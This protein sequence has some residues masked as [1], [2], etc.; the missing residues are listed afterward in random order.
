MA[1]AGDPPVPA[2]SPDGC[3]QDRFAAAA[4]WRDLLGHARPH[5]TASDSQETAPS[6]PASAL[7]L[8]PES[9]ANRA[10]GKPHLPDSPEPSYQNATLHQAAGAKPGEHTLKS[11]R[12]R[13]RRH[14]ENCILAFRRREYPDC[15][16]SQTH[17]APTPATRTLRF[18]CTLFRKSFHFNA[19][20]RICRRGSPTRGED[21]MPW[22]LRW[23]RGA[24]VC[25]V[26]NLLEDR[27]I[28][29]L[30]VARQQQRLRQHLRRPRVVVGKREGYLQSQLS[31]RPLPPSLGRPDSRARPRCPRTMS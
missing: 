26:A 19:L 25:S 30:I 21:R 18:A 2:S 15:R 28:L 23:P 13:R 16:S 31:P 9:N 7:A 24:D 11:I 8:D 3:D 20:Q 1:R 22:P 17:R 14:P 29:D 27:R 4:D 12:I 10:L 6:I 5:G